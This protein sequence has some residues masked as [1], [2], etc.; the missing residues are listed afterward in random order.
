MKILVDK[1][2]QKITENYGTHPYVIITPSTDETNVTDDQQEPGPSTGHNQLEKN[3]S[4]E[5]G[6]EVYLDY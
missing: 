1:A 5:T 4:A 6:Q 3:K 2:H